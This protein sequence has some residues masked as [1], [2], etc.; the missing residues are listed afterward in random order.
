M[1]SINQDKG[2]RLF[3]DV[4]TLC[5][6]SDQVPIQTQSLGKLRFDYEL[7]LLQPVATTE[8]GQFANYLGNTPS[9]PYGDITTNNLEDSLYVSSSV[10]T[11]IYA[12]RPGTYDISNYIMYNTGTP[13][14]VYSYA[15]SVMNTLGTFV[16]GTAATGLHTWIVTAEQVALG[17]YITLTTALSASA[18]TIIKTQIT[19]TSL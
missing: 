2:D 7:E 14:V 12:S 1:D 17:A 3:Y 9:K 18:L 10:P 4:G 6:F 11:R 5:I 15:N 19:K 8:V 16:N 13:S